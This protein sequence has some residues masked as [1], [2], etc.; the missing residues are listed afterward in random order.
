[1]LTFWSKMFGYVYRTDSVVCTAGRLNKRGSCRRISLFGG[2][3]RDRAGGR[4]AETE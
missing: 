1:M 4:L 3:T 2:D